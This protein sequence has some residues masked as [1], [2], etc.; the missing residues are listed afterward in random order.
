[1][2]IFNNL[3]EVTANEIVPGFHAKMFHMEGITVMHVDVKAGSELPEHHHVH[4]QVSN[5]ISGDFEFTINGEKRL[6]KPGDVAT[7]PSNVPH[8]GKALT[9]CKIIDVFQ[10]V[11][12]DY[13][14]E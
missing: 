2:K 7:I 1:M 14:T 5:V 11:R 10:P 13:R 4:E 9:D 3:D 6:C 12:E 8:S